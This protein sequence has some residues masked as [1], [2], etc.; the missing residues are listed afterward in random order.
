MSVSFLCFFFRNQLNKSFNFGLILAHF[1][2]E[3]SNCCL[4]NEVLSLI[5]NEFAQY[6]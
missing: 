6:W 3:F 4:N 1:H 5:L 2:I